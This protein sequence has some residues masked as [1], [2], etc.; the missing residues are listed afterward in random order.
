[1]QKIHLIYHLLP[2]YKTM[3][4]SKTR[5]I[6]QGRKGMGSRNNSFNPA[7]QQ[8]ESPALAGQLEWKA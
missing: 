7:Q 1:M 2:S 5:L 6:N 8:R 3:C 4:P